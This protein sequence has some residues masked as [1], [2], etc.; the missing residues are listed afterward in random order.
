MKKAVIND[1]DCESGG[2]FLVIHGRNPHNLSG[3]EY[4][5]ILLARD[6]DGHL[7]EHLQQLAFRW[8][9]VGMDEETRLA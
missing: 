1:F 5:C 7:E 3:T 9:V 2:A 6:F 4:F 8:S